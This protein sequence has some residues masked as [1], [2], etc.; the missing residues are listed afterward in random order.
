MAER[1]S[2]SLST[3]GN[4]VGP[5]NVDHGSF[6]NTG[7]CATDSTSTP[8]RLV[9][10]PVLVHRGITLSTL[11]PQCVETEPSGHHVDSR[12]ATQWMRGL[13]VAPELVMPGV[14][15]VWAGAV[16]LFLILLRVEC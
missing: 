10:G 3:R 13:G 16:P 6:P 11:A 4:L 12:A 14:G 5:P 7:L 2:V 8:V 15:N 9:L 1:D